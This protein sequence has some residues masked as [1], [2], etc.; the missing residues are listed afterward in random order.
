MAPKLKRKVAILWHAQIRKLKRALV[1]WKVRQVY[2]IDKKNQTGWKVIR[3]VSAQ[4]NKLKR[5][6]DRLSLSSSLH[7]SEQGDRLNWLAPTR[8]CTGNDAAYVARV[9]C[10]VTNNT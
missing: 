3:C 6:G 10:L 5:H 7:L 1:L 8:P 9:S 2:S 4:R